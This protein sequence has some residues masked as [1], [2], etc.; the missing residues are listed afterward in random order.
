MDRNRS[1]R[2]SQA[3]EDKPGR[4]LA[5]EAGR[6]GRGSES[7]RPYLRAQL[8]LKELLVPQFPPPGESLDPK[9]QEDR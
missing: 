8:K 5:A 4:A 2:K 9:T 3:P 1:P 6:S 7:V